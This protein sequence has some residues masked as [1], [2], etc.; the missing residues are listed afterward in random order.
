VA[1]APLGEEELHPS[2][3]PLAAP[4]MSLPMTTLEAFAAIPQAAVCCDQTFGKDEA[5]VI[6]EQ[7]PGST[8]Y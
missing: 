7:L 3:S 8:A 4:A 5:R 6:R 2:D 1:K